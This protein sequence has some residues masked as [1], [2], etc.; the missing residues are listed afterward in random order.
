[1]LVPCDFSRLR[2]ALGGGMAVQRSVAEKWKEI[3]G[4]PLIE[5]YGLT[6]TSPAACVN[7]VTVQDYNGKIGLP[8][9]STIVE[10]RDDE[11]KPLGVGEIGEI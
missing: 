2:A 8:I 5:A 7:P 6:E 9:P 4:R 10:I 11:E 1:M 3:T